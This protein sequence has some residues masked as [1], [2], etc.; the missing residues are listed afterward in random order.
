MTV[1]RFYIVKSLFFLLI[2]FIFL[3]DL[4]LKI[5]NGINFFNQ[6]KIEIEYQIKRVNFKP[7]FIHTNNE[8]SVIQK[9][10]L[11]LLIQPCL[12]HFRSK[13]NL[14]RNDYENL[15]PFTEKPIYDICIWVGVKNVSEKSIVFDHK[16]NYLF[17]NSNLN[18]DGISLKIGTTEHS[19]KFAEESV[20]QISTGLSKKDY[21]RLISINPN[22]TFI[23]KIYIQHEFLIDKYLKENMYIQ[24]FYKNSLQNKD[25]AIPDESVFKDQHIWKGILSSNVEIIRMRK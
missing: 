21:E 14:S 6:D 25:Y 5:L 17:T 23:Y 3:C 16:A 18:K 9:N 15:D 2:I 20:R 24:L 8:N 19:M 13:I 22:E 1:Y 10:G 4:D 12:A 7:E 11:K